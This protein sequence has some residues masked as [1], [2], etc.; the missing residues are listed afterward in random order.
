MVTKSQKRVWGAEVIYSEI[1]NMVS[2]EWGGLAESLFRRA[3][4]KTGDMKK[5]LA[6]PDAWG[7]TLASPTLNRANF[8]DLACPM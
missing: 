7:H 8:K 2:W 1:R 4:T 3:I 5:Q 6:Y